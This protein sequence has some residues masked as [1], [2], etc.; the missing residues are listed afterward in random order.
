[1][2]TSI[3][4]LLRNNPNLLEPNG[5]L[6]PVTCADL[7]EKDEIAGHK[8]KVDWTEARDQAQAYRRYLDELSIDDDLKM[9]SFIIPYD[10]IISLI[11][12]MKEEGLKDK[13]KGITVYIGLETV[14]SNWVPRLFVLP[15]FKDPVSKK[16]QDYKIDNT[17]P[18]KQT[19]A[20]T[21]DYLPE[22]IRPCPNQCSS[23]NFMNN[24]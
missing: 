17:F 4:E 24:P 2:S 9:K 16:Y 15:C 7:I 8:L 13:D 23:D 12:T 19:S 3:Y 14:G 11:N 21:S 5:L 6:P 20:A 22:E 18:P 1:M 10:K